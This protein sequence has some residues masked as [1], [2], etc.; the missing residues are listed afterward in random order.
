VHTSTVQCSTVQF[1]RFTVLILL[2]ERGRNM[3]MN[4]NSMDIECSSSSKENIGG[5]GSA[6]PTNQSR[7]NDHHHNHA[8]EGNS[9]SSGTSS[10]MKIVDAAEAPLN[11]YQKKLKLRRSTRRRTL[12]PMY[13]QTESM[14]DN[15]NDNDNNNDGER[16]RDDDDDGSDDSLA[17]KRARVGVLVL[18]QDN[19]QNDNESAMKITDVDNISVHVHAARGHGHGHGRVFNQETN[20]CTMTPPKQ[21]RPRRSQRRRSLAIQNGTLLLGPCT[22]TNIDNGIGS[23]VGV[24]VSGGPNSALTMQ[25]MSSLSDVSG[26]GLSTFSDSKPLEI[27]SVSASVLE[28]RIQVISASN[29]NPTSDNTQHR[30]DNVQND[31]NDDDGDHNHNHDQM[32]T[33]TCSQSTSSTLSSLCNGVAALMDGTAN[34]V[35][36]CNSTSVSVPKKKRQKKKKQQQKQKHTPAP[37]RRSARIHRRKSTMISS[38]TSSKSTRIK[39]GSSTRT[40]TNDAKKDVTSLSREVEPARTSSLESNVVSIK[41]SLHSSEEEVGKPHLNVNCL[42]QDADG[43][44]GCHADGTS[45]SNKPCPNGNS[46]SETL[47]E[48]NERRA[49]PLILISEHEPSL[50]PHAATRPSCAAKHHVRV[51]AEIDADNVPNVDENTSKSIPSIEMNPPPQNT[52]TSTS[53]CTRALS[54][55]K[56]RRRSSL[57]LHVG[58]LISLKDMEA[59]EH[60]TSR[61]RSRRRSVSARTL[62]P[63]G[64]SASVNVSK[65][66]DTTLDGDNGKM[67]VVGVVGGNTSIIPEADNGKMV[68]MGVVVGASCQ[69]QV[70]VQNNDE[71]ISSENNGGITASTNPSAQVQNDAITVDPKVPLICNGEKGFESAVVEEAM[72]SIPNTAPLEQTHVAIDGEVIQKSVGDDDISVQKEDLVKTAAGD[73]SPCSIMD[74]DKKSSARSHE[75]KPFDVT[76]EEIKLTMG[77]VFNGVDIKRKVSDFHDFGKS[78]LDIK[79]LLTLHAYTFL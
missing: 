42:P 72:E 70:Q 29:A 23:S 33:T 35:N 14:I 34:L 30:L 12:A 41:S 58:G 62:Q 10:G 11:S 78:I 75:T 26:G 17:G 40:C 60:E 22:D 4:M 37:T 31:G 76:A 25:T 47:L 3:N 68:D 2:N 73:I 27:Q 32:A 46:Q 20:T 79:T 45:I 5:I 7:G 13:N 36:S 56:R 55:P 6:S 15:D 71:S 49:M 66:N 19:N 16:E 28:E 61:R 77:E 64:V 53:T 57:G 18:E 59:I 65:S 54:K 9:N 43:N 44:N 52:N 24:G 69:V 74:S 8:D 21:K 48:C 51:D 1:S 63:M 67:M 38:A 39:T 50:S